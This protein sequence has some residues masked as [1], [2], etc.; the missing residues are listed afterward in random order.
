MVIGKRRDEL[1]LDVCGQS[2]GTVKGDACKLC[3]GMALIIR[4]GVTQLIY[5]Y[6]TYLWS[7]AWSI[8]C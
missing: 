7:L 8:E 4:N 3:D 2:N 5:I 6:F 1:L